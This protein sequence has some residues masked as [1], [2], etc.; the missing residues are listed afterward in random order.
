MEKEAI[1]LIETFLEAVQKVD[2]EQLVTLLEP[3]MRW[4]QPGN[5]LVSG[6]KQS[7]G[8]VFQ[9]M[10]KMFA[11]SA[12]TLA[13]AEVKVLAANS[14]QVA[15]LL[16]WTATQPS[17]KK[18]DVENIDVYTIANGKIVEATVFTTDIDQENNFWV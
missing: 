16:R 15:C 8:E 18:L 10:G 7:A 4:S 5:N 2:M 11:L 1:K 14:N 9:M 13:L 3:D 17:G 12:N 6:Y